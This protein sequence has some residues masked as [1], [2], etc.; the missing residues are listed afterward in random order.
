[1]PT[2]PKQTK[3]SM[4]GCKNTRSKMNQWCLDHG[5]QDAYRTKIDEDRAAFNAAYQQRAW[6]RIR[7]AQLSRTPIC[8]ACKT[9][10]II[11]PANQVDHLF[12]WARY[13]KE[14]FIINVFQSLC[15][16]HHAEK[17]WLEDK[18]IFRHYTDAGVRDYNVSDYLHTVSSDD[19]YAHQQAET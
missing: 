11:T 10:G 13:G 9:Q 4:L 3:C 17:G 12:P 14:A 8:Q 16:A 5:G 1:M 6:K 15:A 19:A 2:V 7:M 18:G